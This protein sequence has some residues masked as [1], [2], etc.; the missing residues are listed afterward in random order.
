MARMR[1]LTANEQEAF[2]KPPLFDHK[3]RKQFFDPLKGLM[4][5][6]VSLRSENGQIGFLLMCGYFK[7][8]KRFYQPQDFHERDIEAV[9]RVLGLSGANFSPNA[10]AKQTRARHHQLILDFYGFATFDES[11]LAIEIATMA[12][13]HLKPRLIFDRCVDFL[14]QRR[15]AVPTSRSLTDSIRTG[16]HDRKVELIGLMDD[17]LSHDGRHL[18]DNLFAAPE[19]TNRYRL[20][21]LKKLSQSTKPTKIKEAVADFD[22]LSDLHHQLAPIIHEGA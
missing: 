10:Y 6:A 17:H 16:L 19:D 5:M 3:E 1:I 14:V 15:I 18:L 9:A 21:L 12:R 4:E 22:T 8:T 2:D 20:T 7:A 13:M 11:A